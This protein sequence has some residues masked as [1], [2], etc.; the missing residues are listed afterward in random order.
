MAAS[1]AQLET[2]ISKHRNEPDAALSDKIHEVAKELVDRALL[3]PKG[4]SEYL[5]EL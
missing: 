1:I 3:S 5:S 4:A 2:L